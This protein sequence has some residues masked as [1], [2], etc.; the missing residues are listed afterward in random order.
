VTARAQKYFAQF[1]N[2][3]LKG[4]R[5]YERKKKE[6]RRGEKKFGEEKK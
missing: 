5:K 6:E 1:L 2:A 3:I 4:R